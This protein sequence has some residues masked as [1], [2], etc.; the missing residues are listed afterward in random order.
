MESVLLAAGVKVWALLADTAAGKAIDAGWKRLRKDNWTIRLGNSA[1]RAAGR[2]WARRRLIRWFRSPGVREQLEHRMSEAAIDSAISQYLRD[3]RPLLFNRTRYSSQ[4][5]AETSRL[6]AHEVERRFV[7]SL[8]AAESVS[9]AL[10]RTLPILD[11]LAATE[12]SSPE[13][14]AL[15]GALPVLVRRRARELLAED[16]RGTIRLLKQLARVDVPRAGAIQ[17]LLAP[18][19]PDWVQNLPDLVWVLL[20]EDASAYLLATLARDLFVRAADL[21]VPTRGW[22]LL[23]AAI[24][25]KALGHIGQANDLV[26]RAGELLGAHHQLVGL[27]RAWIAEDWKTCLAAASETKEVEIGGF[28][29]P[30]YRAAALSQLQRGD[31]A[32]E[33][34]DQALRHEPESS[35]CLLLKARLL[36]VRGSRADGLVRDR[37]LKEAFELANR[38]RGLRRQWGAISGEC[39]DVMIDAELLRGKRDAAFAL[40]LPPPE[41]TATA[42]EATYPGVLEAVGLLAVDRKR[43]DLAQQAADQLPVGSPGRLLIEGVIAVGAGQGALG[44]EMLM[45]AV[46]QA[47]DPAQK[48]KAIR[49]LATAGVWPPPASIEMLES[50]DDRRYLEGLARFK[51]GRLADA[52]AILEPLSKGLRGAAELLA[53]VYEAQHDPDGAV[54]VFDAAAEQ[55]GEP[56]FKVQAAFVLADARRN[57]E[58]L[59]RGADAMRH[60]FPSSPLQRKVRRM[61]ANVSWRLENFREVRAQARALL[62]DVPDDADA[63]WLLAGSE[64]K[65]GVP[66][67]AWAT[68]RRYN[69]HPRHELEACV[70]LGVASLQVP[71]TEWLPIAHDLLAQFGGGQ[72]A[73]MFKEL[74]DRRL[75][76]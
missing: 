38:A 28:F 34:I 68:M 69:M 16:A 37:D 25:E 46:R 9:V 75:R 57:Q 74:S 65:L 12:L 40:G 70:W 30:F 6:I 31:E 35:T 64:A 76:G 62:A 21:G 19:I 39:V 32:L 71:L 24:C 52:I 73:A 14:E 44:K 2:G 66:A 18:P 23:R 4:A 51:Q 17:E 13:L 59:D 15:L 33:E 11:H 48:A 20:A 26:D 50:M 42:E 22:W 60:L 55:F 5:L 67:D 63:Q 7:G 45:E 53:E 56:D 36:L 47:T 49:A 29:M 10:D 8:D 3:H 61:M 58:A 54:A 41:G 72:Y 1:S 27:C 43:T